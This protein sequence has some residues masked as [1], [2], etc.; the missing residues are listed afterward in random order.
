MPIGHALL[1]SVFLILVAVSAAVVASM[2]LLALF[3]RVFGRE[4]P[5][6]AA[7]IESGQE[8]LRA[9]NSSCRSRAPPS[10]RLSPG[11]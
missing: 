8:S 7:D 10:Q 2:V 4:K 11:L 6:K 5:S 9:P 1:T 3:D